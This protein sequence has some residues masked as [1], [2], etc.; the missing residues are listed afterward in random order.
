MRSLLNLVSTLDREEIFPVVVCSTGSS[1]IKLFEEKG[2][3]VETATMPWFT[4]KAGLV[5][6][7][8]YF[9]YLLSFAVFL[10]KV[11]RKYKIQIIHANTFIAALYAVLPAKISG[12]PLVWHMREILAVDSINKI[13]IMFA[14]WGSR[15]IICVSNAVKERLMRFGIDKGKC[16]IIYNFILSPF[17]LEAGSFKKELNLSNDTP[18]I[19]MI[20]PISRLKGQMIF[21]EAIPQ[22][23]NLFP[24]SKFVIVGEISHDGEKEYKLKMERTIEQ[25]DL[26]DKVLFTGFRKDIFS[27]LNDI[28]IVVHASIEPDSLPNAIMEAM[29]MG[30][31]VVATNMGGA[32][33]M[34]IDGVNGFIV[35]PHDSK[36]LAEAICKL[37]EDKNLRNKMGEE[38]KRIAI[39]KFNFKTYIEKLNKVY[40]ELLED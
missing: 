25:F 40:Q 34:V 28:D 39:K 17:R 1:I 12:R 32:S 37:I 15:R 38:G 21:I 3:K 33:E 24:I 8:S 27:T 16:S 14:N 9:F 10:Q 2:I 19:G 4:R 18:L 36:S 22:I 23:L 35:P 5:Q 31:P 6:L 7:F 13:F 26:M 29:I 30:R 20:S 11:I